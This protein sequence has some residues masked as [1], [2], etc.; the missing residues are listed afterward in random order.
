MKTKIISGLLSAILI[1]PAFAAR[2]I[3]AQSYGDMTDFELGA[4]KNM[5]DKHDALFDS[6]YGA[7]KKLSNA[8]LASVIGVILDGAAVATGIIKDSRSARADAKYGDDLAKMADADL[9]KEFESA[10]SADCA[11]D[12]SKNPDAYKDSKD[13]DGKTIKAK[14]CDDLKNDIFKTSEGKEVSNDAMIAYLV[15]KNDSNAGFNQT[16][17]WVRMG[18]AAG[19]LI[20]NVI[21]VSVIGSVANDLADAKT[22]EW[23]SAV[24][25]FKEIAMQAHTEGRDNNPMMEI[26]KCANNIDVSKPAKNLKTAKTFQIVGAVAN[27]GSAIASGAGNINAV[28]EKDGLNNGLNKGATIAA[29]VGAG[30]SV[31]SIVIVASNKSTIGK[32]RKKLTACE[33]YLYWDDNGHAYRTEQDII[34]KGKV[35]LSSYSQWKNYCAS[36]TN[37]GDCMDKIEPATADSSHSGNYTIPN[38]GV[39][40]KFSTYSEAEIEKNKAS[41]YKFNVL[42]SAASGTDWYVIRHNGDLLA[43]VCRFESNKCIPHGIGL[44]SHTNGAKTELYI[45]NRYN[46][47]E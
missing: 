17:N 40:Q 25:E 34:S 29:G 2:P 7:E 19:G 26:A 9:K 21:S 43:N 30:A 22:N 18:A 23:N 35:T 45:E 12:K 36:A 28:K 27:A 42:A 24:K 5:R 46:F 15:N 47:G 1:T 14:T 38:G 11:A 3:D 8:M 32:E 10:F 4:I 6:I 16:M 41:S 13:A 37:A 39:Q 31:V 44:L 20:T 33:E